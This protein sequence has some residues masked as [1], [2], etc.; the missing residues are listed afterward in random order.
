[1]QE[2]PAA[3]PYEKWISLLRVSTAHEKLQTFKRFPLHLDEIQT[4][5]SLGAGTQ[6]DKEM[7]LQNFQSSEANAEIHVA[8]LDRRQSKQKPK[9]GT[10][11]TIAVKIFF[12]LFVDCWVPLRRRFFYFF[13]NTNNKRWYKEIRDAHEFLT[14][15]KLSAY[16]LIA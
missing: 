12:I 2:V 11:N 7:W 14:S 1:M 8:L 13:I 15:W 9:S 4:V 16:S 10:I 3:P 5:E 6:T